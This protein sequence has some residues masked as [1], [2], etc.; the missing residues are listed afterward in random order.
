MSWMSRLF[1]N[2]VVEPPPHGAISTAPSAA[3]PSPLTSSR[4][5]TEVASLARTKYREGYAIADVDAFVERVATALEERAR[6]YRP[7]LTAD[8]VLRA[9]FAAT[10][11]QE[12]YDQDDVDQL[13]D[14]VARSL[15]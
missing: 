10:K 4:L 11:F 7:S 1:G 6:G 2:T 12:G 5:R 8:Q 14:R 15:A 3:T 9:R 13:L